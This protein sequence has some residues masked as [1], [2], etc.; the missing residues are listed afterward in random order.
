MWSSEKMGTV[1]FEERAEK[2]APAGCRVKGWSRSVEGDD[3]AAARG[4]GRDR[5]RRAWRRWGA[6]ELQL[7]DSP[8]MSS[9][10]R[11]SHHCAMSK[12]QTCHVEAPCWHPKHVRPAHAHRAR[13]LRK[14][15]SHR[16]PWDARRPSRMLAGERWQRGR[17]SSAAGWRRGV[18][19]GKRLHCLFLF[20]QIPAA[21]IRLDGSAYAR[22]GR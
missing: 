6:A 17:R 14:N 7:G 20:N 12:V 10:S 19:A 1:M 22:G 15:Q 11:G 9:T 3:D 8:A 4:G 2:W 18:R 16:R 13:S 5:W 21:S